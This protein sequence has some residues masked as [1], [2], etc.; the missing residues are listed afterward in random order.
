M[1]QVL[2]SLDGFHRSINYLMESKLSRTKKIEL[3]NFLKGVYVVGSVVINVND[4]LD[5]YFHHPDP[6]VK[7]KRVKRLNH[8]IPPYLEQTLNLDFLSFLSTDRFY[9]NNGRSLTNHIFTDNKELYTDKLGY[10]RVLNF[11]GF[12]IIKLNALFDR[13]E[14]RDYQALKFV[15]NYFGQ[16][17]PEDIEDIIDD[18]GLENCFAKF[19]AKFNPQIPSV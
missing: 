3:F 19:K 5:L 16:K 11:K 2:K 10:I 13:D 4:D 17:I 14:E 6:E 18:F 12:F 1:E 15:Y 9:N 8:L 7:R